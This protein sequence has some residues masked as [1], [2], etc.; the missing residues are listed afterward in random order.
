MR[1]RSRHCFWSGAGGLRLKIVTNKG[2]LAEKLW[3]LDTVERRWDMLAPSVR[4]YGAPGND[5]RPAVILFHG[6]AGVR[7]HF[8]TYAEAAAQE[9]YRAFIVDSYEPRG[10]SQ[11]YATTMVCS[12]AMFW[13]RERAG[14]VLA[15][16]WGLSQDPGVDASRIALAGWSHGAWSIMDLMTMPLERPGEASLADASGAC[17]AG[18]KSLFLAYPYGGPGALS[19]SR[20]WVRA[21]ETFGVVAERD[22]L[23]AQA[24]ALRVF[25][26]PRHRGAD[27][28]VWIAPGTHA[29]DA[30]GHEGFPSPMRY[31]AELAGEMLQ[32]FNSFLHRTLDR[33]AARVMQSAG[34][35]AIDA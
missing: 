35:R 29:F 20:G 2:S 17:L 24:D 19:R 26:A 5:P 12:G 13:G 9:G 21:P 6:C 7:P 27:V 28:D 31:D 23:T 4:P 10:W 1:L 14:D 34:E 22:H 3:P 25:D 33:P 8:D 16:V 18:V 30:P 11:G 15:A 32:R